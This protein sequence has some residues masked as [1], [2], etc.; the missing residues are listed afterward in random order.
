MK[1]IPE[2][3]R[4]PAWKWMGTLPNQYRHIDLVADTYQ[5]V[6]IKNYKRLYLG[7]S[8]L[9]MINSSASKVPRDFTKFMK[10]SENKTCLINLICKAISNNYKRALVLLK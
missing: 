5:E 8:V 3:Y 1:K 9:L 6:S 4:Q 10:C 7:I 2:A